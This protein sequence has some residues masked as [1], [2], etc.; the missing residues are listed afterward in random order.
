MIK[1]V[2]IVLLVVL[3]I[4]QFFRIDKINPPVDATINLI[5]VVEVPTTVQ[6]ILTSACFDCHSNET[7]YPWYTNVAPLSWWIKDH[8]DEGRDELNFSE[9]GSY[10][11]KRRLHKI[12]ELGEMVSEG[13]M[14]LKSYVIAHREADLSDAQRNTL[15]EWIKTLK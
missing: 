7:A 10:S 9:W 1:K 4:I 3:V 6:E 15:L 5:Q 13:E 2:L 11:D 8:I 14:P 12:D